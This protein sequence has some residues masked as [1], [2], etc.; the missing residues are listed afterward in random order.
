MQPRQHKQVVAISLE[1]RRNFR[2]VATSGQAD[3]PFQIDVLVTRNVSI[4]LRHLPVKIS[5]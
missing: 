4:G 1:Q 5:E 2:F 3:P